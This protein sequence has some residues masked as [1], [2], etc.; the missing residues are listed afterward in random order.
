[1]P[2]SRTTSSADGHVYVAFRRLGSSAELVVRD[3]GMGIHPEFLPRV[4]ERFRQAEA[5]LTRSHTGLGLGLAIVRHLIELHGGAVTAESPG[6]G[7]GATF[8]SRMP[9]A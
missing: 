1:M 2:V 3:T 6:G 7:L 5:P 9:L 4:F 8:T